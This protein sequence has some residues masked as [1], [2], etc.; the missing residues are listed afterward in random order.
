MSFVYIYIDES[1]KDSDY[2]ETP[3]S[4]MRK[5]ISKMN[6]FSNAVKSLPTNNYSLLC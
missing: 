4:P 1:N 3:L 5:N 2:S 6:V